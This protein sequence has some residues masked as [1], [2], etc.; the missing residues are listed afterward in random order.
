MMTPVD[1]ATS[2]DC[3]ALGRKS[4]LEW[5]H[6]MRMRLSSDKIVIFSFFVAAIL[7]GS[8]LLSLPMSWK[9]EEPLEYIDALFTATSAVCVTG[10][11][12]VDTAMYS[13]LGQTLIALLIQAGGLGIISF[14]TI[15]VAM[16]R[17][18]VSVASR[19]IIKDFYLEEVEHD[20]KRIVRDIVLATFAIEGL[21]AILLSFRFGNLADGWF[22]SLFHA[23]S[24]F[25]N[26]G[27]STFPTN[28]EAYVGDPLVNLTVIGLILAGGIGFMVLRDL[29]R[30][31][32][33]RSRRLSLHSRIAVL[34]SLALV[35]FGAIVFHAL[36]R[37]HAMRELSAFGRILASLF[38][39]VTPRTAGFNTLPQ[40]SLSGG[41]Q[42]LTMLLMFIGASPGSTGGGVK[43]TT[44][45]VLLMAA[46]KGT[47]EKDR[48]NLGGRSI[49]PKTVIKAVGIVV[50][51]LAIVMT[52]AFLVLVLE[53]SSGSEVG[54]I[55]V[56]FES[57]SAFAT[58]GLSLGITPA[59]SSA[60]KLVLV[61][62][63]FAGRVGLFAM[64]IPRPGRAIEHWAD[65]PTADL[66]VG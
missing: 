12:T 47:D 42:L 54:M 57:V 28:F 15:Y 39:A 49:T 22:V 1:A 14:A 65:R 9:G 30:R 6:V 55:Q 33:G 19:G 44:F 21:G 26:A 56:F 64:A 34:T 53:R 11:I 46:L 16:P 31:A 35:L 17:T 24:A 10:L 63:M 61:L 8:L 41:S 27:F 51:A 5:I 38:Q 7:I 58:V 36:E 32:A 29:A 59:L 13:R 66:M 48:L 45:F 60:S 18:R 20:P 37:A 4:V 25:C 2:R 23:I 62:T 40:N 50:K 3:L 52:S 43:T